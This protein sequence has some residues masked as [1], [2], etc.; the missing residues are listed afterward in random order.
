MLPDQEVVHKVCNE[1]SI[2]IGNVEL[3]T[4]LHILDFIDN[5]EKDILQIFMLQLYLDP[6]HK[7]LK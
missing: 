1:E 5:T 4:K 3:H 7:S 6:V 2:Y